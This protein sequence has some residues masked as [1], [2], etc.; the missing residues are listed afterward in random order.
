MNLDKIYQRLPYWLQNISI[1][2]YGYMIYNRRYSGYYKQKVKD[3]IN[4]EKLSV[5]EINDLQFELLRKMLINAYQ[6]VPYYRNL[7]KANNFNPEL[8]FTPEDFAKV[9]ALT[10]NTI[11]SDV[12]LFISEKA[13]RKKLIRD[14]T[15]GTSGN[16]LELWFTDDE[17]KYNFAIYDVRLKRVF[18]VKTG[19]KI[20]SFLSKKLCP[21]DQKKPPFWRYN[22]A[23]NQILFSTYHLNDTTAEYYVDHLR[24]YS[25]NLIVGYPMPLYLMAKYIVDRKLEPIPIKA[26]FTSSETLYDYQ[27]ETIEKAFSTRICNGYSQGEGVAMI[28]ECEYGKLHVQPEYGYIEFVDVPGNDFKE[29]VGTTLFNYNMPLIR[30]RTGDYVKLSEETE[31]KC[32]RPFFPIVETIIG[33]DDST[34]KRRDGRQV[35]ASHFA[36]PF[37]T[38]TDIIE[39]QVIQEDYDNITAKLVIKPD[40]TDFDGFIFE[41]HR[42]LGNDVNV[43]LEVV[44]AIEKTVSGKYKFI[45][46]KVK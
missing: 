45:I 13:D 18:G 6:N 22:K 20:A 1:S 41:M 19:D 3:F 34:F 39:A 46:S 33:R 35:S 2:L 17:I 4:N 43:K 16:P 44:D 31:C 29:V 37:R 9:P 15:G 28:S 14:M 36:Q 25:P 21:T 12:N 5:K 24:K 38:Y 32:G 11:K 8:P 7:F 40:F 27:R 42:I 23:Y 26:A 30:Y 10:K